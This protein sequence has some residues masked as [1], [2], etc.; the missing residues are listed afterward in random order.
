MRVYLNTVDKVKRFVAVA[1]RF[2][3]AIDLSAGRFLVDGKSILGIFSIDLRQPLELVTYG[4]HQE[5]E[6]LAAVKEFAA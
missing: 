4:G 3:D 2:E 5:Q 1:S 6:I